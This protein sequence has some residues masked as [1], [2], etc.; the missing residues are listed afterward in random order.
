MG[1]MEKIIEALETRGCK[2]RNGSYQC[3]AHDDQHESLSVRET[4]PGGIGIKCHRGCS[5]DEIMEA[6][7]MSTAELFDEKPHE[8]A[9]YRYMDRNGTVLFAKSRQEPKHFTLLRPVDGGWEYGLDGVAERPLYR[10]PEVIGAVARGQI[11][12]VVE[13]EKDADRLWDKDIAA[14]C[15]FGGA[16]EWRDEYSDYLT[17]AD[18]II[19]ADRD[20][21][22]ERHAM[23]IRA[24][25]RG[26]ARS[27]R[28][29]QSRTEGKGHDV[30]DH[31][32][33]GYDI[34]ELLPLNFNRLYKRVDLSQALAKGIEKPVLLNELLY[35]GGL[36]SIAGAPDC[37]KTTLAAWWALQELRRGNTVAFFDEEGGADI[38]TEKFQSLGASPADL[39]NIAYFPFPGKS[40][41]DEE[42]DSLLDLMGDISPTVVL[43]DSSAAFLARAGLDENRATDVTNWWSR[44]MTPI[45]RDYKAAVLVVDHDTKSS[46]QSRYAR[47]S[48]AKLGALDVQ[49]KVIMARPFTRDQDGLLRVTVTKDRR[50]WLHRYWKVEMS[51]NGRI[52]PSFSHDEPDAEIPEGP[53]AR[54]KIYEVLDDVP[55]GYKAIV[56]AINERYGHFLARATVSTELNELLREGRVDSIEQP[57]RETLWIRRI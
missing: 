13:G 56:D 19:V 57:G 14:T 10:L 30:S 22:G 18:V 50:G 42:V 43:W 28:I 17:G 46:E 12:Y 33:A 35:Q 55:K 3:P 5:A 8:V 53:P 31:L 25:L 15:N 48:G 38:I 36:H 1:A 54:K 32:E 41:T 20:E 29:V 34:N 2:G 27:A 51:T 4:R 7:D 45:A 11:I 21:P 49:I 16:D 44:V 23:K 40:W 47:G 9:R 39:A 24:S 52:I 37:G 26:K 6:L